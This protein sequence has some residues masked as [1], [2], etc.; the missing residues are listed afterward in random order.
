MA[1]VRA[2]RPA[3]AKAEAD[4]YF[5]RWLVDGPW[6]YLDYATGQPQPYEQIAYDVRTIAV[7]LTDLFGATGDARYAVMAGLAASWFTGN[8]APGVA[9]YDPASGRGY[10]GI[11]AP[12]TVNRNSGAE[13]T[14]EALMTFQEVNRH[15]EARAWLHAKGA[16]PAEKTFE[17]AR[18]RYRVFTAGAGPSSRRGAL[19]L[20]LDR[21][22]SAWLDGAALDR[23]L[24]P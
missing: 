17:G 21:G 8:N 11:N 18:V 3:S 24:A 23:L 19:V 12:T 4:S 2:G 9:M 7:G 20:N 13:S 15:P 10:D 14:V 22:T 1:L 16:P 5:A 6:H